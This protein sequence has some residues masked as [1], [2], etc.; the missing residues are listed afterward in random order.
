MGNGSTGT[1]SSTDVFRKVLSNKYFFITSSFN[2]AAVV[3]DG[4]DGGVVV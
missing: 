3:D 1:T 2:A 4:Y